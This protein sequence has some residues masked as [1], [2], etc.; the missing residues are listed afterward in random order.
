[1][2]SE[3]T[4]E[5]ERERKTENIAKMKSNKQKERTKKSTQENIKIN[6]K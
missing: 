5:M 1:M 4:G 2:K 3:T 6:R